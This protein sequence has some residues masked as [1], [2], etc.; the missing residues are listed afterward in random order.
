[1]SVATRQQ[2]SVDSFPKPLPKA[3]Q[4]SPYAASV[5]APG[6]HKKISRGKSSDKI[7]SL[8]SGGRQRRVSR[9]DRSESSSHNATE[10]YVPSMNTNQREVG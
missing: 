7:G 8:G 9:G 6:L 5:M 4:N 1:M 3:L 2:S 10:L